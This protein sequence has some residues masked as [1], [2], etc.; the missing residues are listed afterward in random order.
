MW[1]QSIQFLIHAA[2]IHVHPLDRA[3]QKVRLRIVNETN[4]FVRHQVYD[5]YPRGIITTPLSFEISDTLPIS[6]LCSPQ[7]MMLHLLCHDLASALLDPT[8]FPSYLTSDHNTSVLKSAGFYNIT[9]TEGYE[10]TQ[11][12]TSSTFSLPDCQWLWC[13]LQ[14]SNYGDKQSQ[15]IHS[16]FVSPYAECNGTSFYR[17]YF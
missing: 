12:H 7:K 1:L 5:E 14:N 15:R 4:Q 17:R 6:Q 3:T 16:Y 2:N 8:A 10:E 13:E 11:F 9:L